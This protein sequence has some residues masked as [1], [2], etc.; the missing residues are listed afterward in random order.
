MATIHTSISSTF[1]CEYAA[2]LRTPLPL[3]TALRFMYLPRMIAKSDGARDKL[4]GV[5]G[6]FLLL[7]E[8]VELASYAFL[9]LGYVTVSAGGCKKSTTYVQN[10]RKRLSV[11][12]DNLLT[13][14]TVTISLKFLAT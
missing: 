13:T 5:I 7:S 9:N 8:L 2:T 14:V 11:V 12:L 3:K 1:L 4:F 10:T 6:R